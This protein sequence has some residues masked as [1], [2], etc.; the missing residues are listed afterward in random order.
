METNSLFSNKNPE[1]LRKYQL[2][3]SPKVWWKRA[4]ARAS[5]IPRSIDRGGW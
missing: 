5:R 1:L 4:G 2:S 3:L